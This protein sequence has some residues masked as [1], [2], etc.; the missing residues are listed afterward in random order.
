MFGVVLGGRDIGV[1][2][3]QVGR[4]S[5]LKRQFAGFDLVEDFDRQIILGGLPRIL[6]NPRSGSQA[7]TEGLPLA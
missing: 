7:L 3:R 1:A 4:F 2:H 6:S 5:D